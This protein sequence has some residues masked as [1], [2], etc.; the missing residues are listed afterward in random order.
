MNN[1]NSKPFDIRR[2]VVQGSPLSALLFILALEPLLTTAI[3]DPSY[4]SFRIFATLMFVLGYCDD[5]FI[6]T[7]LLG[8]FKWMT[9]L[10]KWRYLSGDKLND[11]KC[12]INLIGKEDTT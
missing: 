12:L 6:F 11:A 3:D 7:T 8:L 2:G 5:L 10:D 9:L 4:G 1:T